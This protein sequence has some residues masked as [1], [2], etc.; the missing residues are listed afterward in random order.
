[1]PLLLPHNR[2][3]PL[4]RPLIMGI[5]N[6]T[7]D[8]FSDGGQYLDIQSAIA[9]GLEMAEQGAD[10]LDVGG[11]STRPG[12]APVEP[13]EQIRRTAEVIAGLR[14]HL[15]ARAEQLKQQLNQ[16]G[17]PNRGLDRV[18]I[19]IDTS[20]VAVATAALEAGAEIINDIYA[21]RDPRNP[22]P[23]AMFELAAQDSAAL[24]LMHMQGTPATMQQNPAYADVVGE[25]E[26]FLLERAAAAQAA[27]WNASELCL[28]PALASARTKTTTWRCLPI[29]PAW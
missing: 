26:A 9:H 6:V 28:I 19:S 24:V 14:A 5:L 8:S 18:T 20:L 7:P 21:G 23:S 2:Q 10:I 1:M 13:Q 17:R 4:D 25:V 27:G 22:S 16:Q 3:L 15:D 12:S 29:W 11:E